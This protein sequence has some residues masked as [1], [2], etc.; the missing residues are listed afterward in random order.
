MGA[1]RMEETLELKEDLTVNVTCSVTGR[2]PLTVECSAAGGLEKEHE[3]RNMKE[4]LSYK[5]FFQN[6]RGSDL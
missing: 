6:S 5:V 2:R 3:G 4:D 1:G